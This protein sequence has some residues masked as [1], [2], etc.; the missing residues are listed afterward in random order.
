MTNYLSAV[1]AK[2]SLIYDTIIVQCFQC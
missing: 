1:T 2:F